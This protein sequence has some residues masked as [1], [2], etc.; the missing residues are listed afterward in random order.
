MAIAAYILLF[1]FYAWLVLSAI[2]FIWWFLQFDFQRSWVLA[3][4]E[5]KRTE[6]VVCVGTWIS[7]CIVLSLGLEKCLWFIPGDWG[8]FDEGGDFVTLRSSI[9]M[10]LAFALSVFSMYVFGRFVKIRNE[11]RQ[12]TLA[13]EIQKLKDKDRRSL[14]F[15]TEE[16][17]ETAA[18]LENLRRHHIPGKRFRD[19]TRTKRGR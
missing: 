8:G 9:A 2:L 19:P 15:L 1:V 3:K 18:K 17:D 5:N 13:S 10:S 7:L 11:N 12:L 16:R 6:Y 14:V 4:W